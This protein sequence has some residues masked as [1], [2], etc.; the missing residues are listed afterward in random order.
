M[1]KHVLCVVSLIC[2]A[3]F[4]F[5]CRDAGDLRKEETL[6]IA[7]DGMCE[8][9]VVCADEEADKAEQLAGM[10]SEKYGV[11]PRILTDGAEPSERE[12]VIG[13]TAREES[14][15]AKELLL[16]DSFT[17]LAV[18]E[19]IVIY[20]SDSNR[21]NDAILY[22]IS[23]YALDTLSVPLSLGVLDLGEERKN[24]DYRINKA[25]VELLSDKSIDIRAEQD[26][27]VEVEMRS[28]RGVEI[29]SSKEKLTVLHKDSFC[30]L[31]VTPYRIGKGDD[32]IYGR[33]ELFVYDGERL[34]THGDLITNGECL[35]IENATELV[36]FADMH[37]R[38]RAVNARIF[39]DIDMNGFF[40]KTVP[41]L[42]GVLDGGGY[43]VSEIRLE[44]MGNDR[45][46][47]FSLLREGAVV[48]D[49]RLEGVS[50]AANGN[51]YV[52]AVAAESR[53]RIENV[54]VCGRLTSAGALGTD[55]A[56]NSRTS[57]GAIG[58]IVGKCDG[59]YGAVIENSSFS[60][61]ITVREMHVTLVGGIVGYVSGAGALVRESHFD[62]KL[63]I[64]SQNS[65]DNID[66]VS[67]GGIA[68]G[69]SSSLILGCS[70]SGDVTSA[71]PGHSL[72]GGICGAL[73]SAGV[74]ADCESKDGSVIT[75]VGAGAAS[76][77]ILGGF[78]SPYISAGA[79]KGCVSYAT[80]LANRGCAGGIAGYTLERAFVFYSFNCGEVYS[81]ICSGGIL[82]RAD[83]DEDVFLIG[84]LN[85]DNVCMGAVVGD[86]GEATVLSKN[87]VWY[88]EHRGDSLGIGYGKEEIFLQLD[89]EYYSAQGGEPCMIW[90][91]DRERIN[92][93]IPL[94]LYAQ[95]S[96]K[97]KGRL[98][99]VSKYFSE[100]CDGENRI[101]AEHFA[102]SAE[103]GGKEHSV[104]RGDEKKPCFCSAFEKDHFFT[105][106]EWTILL[107]L[108]E[109]NIS[110]IS[111]ITNF[112]E[113]K[114]VGVICS[115]VS[116]SGTSVKGYCRRLTDDSALCT[117]IAYSPDIFASSDADF[118]R[119]VC[120]ELSHAMSMDV[121]VESWMTEGY[122]TFVTCLVI[123]DE[124]VEGY[125]FKRD[126]IRKEY[127]P[128][129]AFYKRLCEIYK[130]RALV[131][132]REIG[133][134]GSGGCEML[135]LEA[136]GLTCTD[137][138]EK[139]FY[140]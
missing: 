77:G 105:H 97:S 64:Y 112:G 74:I 6:L 8:Y 106:G 41:R 55:S 17:I 28:S 43:T 68:G 119:T 103:S 51:R 128:T 39:S 25:S 93:E 38:G 109:E 121:A 30:S 72:A 21:L 20:A 120:H 124:R 91:G 54:Q 84:C 134:R 71:G 79:V 32:K 48:R 18:D 19:K 139:C 88:S 56:Y 40:W 100:I 11:L 22:F 90:Q 115:D 34:V 14:A 125:V 10:I 89:G 69:M 65:P 4:L 82:G 58:G 98:S 81:Q 33:S 66:G 104:I 5:S 70:L 27:F 29:F 126:D 99:L 78:S 67:V 140:E 52:G 87:N 118:K 127:T 42:S 136:F 113:I 44:E 130:S 83:T 2:L 133:E 7:R 61:E 80:V 24:V 73:L 131:L 60:G 45:L 9:T 114:T 94:S 46:G 59:A 3:L 35:R 57:M 23:E 101:S 110:E 116:L 137:L 95:K 15:L 102:A 117:K 31:E 76:G 107:D 16:D 132:I 49:L 85:G 47:L 36:L 12:I 13:E 75:V 92:G 111:D 62:G 53:G 123:G 135:W 50:I 122:A 129:A 63:E 26:V 138:W 1:K 37:R 96:E 108:I 86:A